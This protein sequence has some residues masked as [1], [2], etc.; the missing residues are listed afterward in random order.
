MTQSTINELVHRHQEF[1]S[2]YETFQALGLSLDMT[3]LVVAL[4]FLFERVPTHEL[5]AVV[6]YGVIVVLSVLHV[7]PFR[8]TK[9]VGYW[10]HA[11]TTFVL[12]STAVF[13]WQLLH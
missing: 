9:M 13:G 2:A 10:Y 12:T 8:M 5:F 7:A 3:A 1:K 4:L 6:L 11:V